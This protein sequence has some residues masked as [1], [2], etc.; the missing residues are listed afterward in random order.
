[1]KSR[2]I[3]KR[4]RVNTFWNVSGQK[5]KQLVYQPKAPITPV[6]LLEG[7][8]VGQSSG[9]SIHPAADGTLDGE[10][11]AAASDNN[12]DSNKKMRKGS[13]DQAGAVKQP[14]QTQ[15]ESFGV[16]LSRAGVGRDSRRAS[17]VSEDISTLPPLFIRD[18]DEGR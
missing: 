11:D 13:A 10:H 8:T 4:L 18:K 3:N 17:L 6:L 9:V 1:M 2:L 14:R 16:E 5:R 7:P 12:V 15:Y